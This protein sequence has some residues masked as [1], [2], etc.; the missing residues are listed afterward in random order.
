MIFWAN[1]TYLCK[2]IFN[3]K[4]FYTVHV[5]LES[6]ACWHESPMQIF[7]LTMYSEKCLKVEYFFTQTCFIYSKDHSL[8][9]AN[10][11]QRT[12]PMCYNALHVHYPCIIK[13]LM[14][15]ICHVMHV[16]LFPMHSISGNDLC[17]ES[18]F[19]NPRFLTTNGLGNTKN[20]A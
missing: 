19:Q 18:L 6:Y 10:Y 8:L 16:W 15:A 12:S 4:K 5:G 9:S 3:F 1:K 20:Q 13:F 7:N 14:A 2:K 11:L 17:P